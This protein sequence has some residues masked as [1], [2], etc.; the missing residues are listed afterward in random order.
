MTITEL[1]N[2]VA[3]SFQKPIEVRIAKSPDPNRLPDRYV[4][5]TK[6]AQTDLG[7]R[8]IV[9]LK[10]AIQ[11]TIAYHYKSMGNSQ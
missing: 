3:Q 9:N 10:E 6:R 4:P 8:Q 5:A 2:T 1:A 7:L 11:R